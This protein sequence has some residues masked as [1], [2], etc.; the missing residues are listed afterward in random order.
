MKSQDIFISRRLLDGIIFKKIECHH[1]NEINLL[2][3]Y[4]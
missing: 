3:I 1:S 4:C 2:K